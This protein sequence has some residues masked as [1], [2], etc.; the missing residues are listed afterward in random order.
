M[1]KTIG[2]SNTGPE[3]HELIYEKSILSQPLSQIALELNCP[4]CTIQSIVKRRV[5]RGHN[6]DSPRSGRPTKLTEHDI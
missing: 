1:P 4:L 2:R 3:L 5:E 6:G